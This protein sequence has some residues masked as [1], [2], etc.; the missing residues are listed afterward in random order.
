LEGEQKPVKHEYFGS[1]DDFPMEE[2]PEFLETDLKLLVDTVMILN[3][4]SHNQKEFEE[5]MKYFDERTTMIKPK[6][7][8]YYFEGVV[9][10]ELHDKGNGKSK[11]M[12]RREREST[13][14]IIQFIEKKQQVEDGNEPKYEE[15][16][17]NPPIETCPYQLEVNFANI[18]KALNKFNPKD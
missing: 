17:N 6:D 8:E 16:A 12:F 4:Q 1:N 5:T 7:I 2:F 13:H 14:E 9:M 11:V 10:K 3:N 15:D 18:M